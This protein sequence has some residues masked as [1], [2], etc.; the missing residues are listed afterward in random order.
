M[1]L[2]VAG[3]VIDIA[4]K[5]APYI[6]DGVKYAV[7]V[8]KNHVGRI[9]AL[10][11]ID[12]L[13]TEKE[14]QVAEL[15]GWFSANNIALPR[16]GSGILETIRDWVDNASQN[17]YKGKE[18]SK[19]EN[20]ARLEG[21]RLILEATKKKVMDAKKVGGMVG[22]HALKHRIVGG[23]VMVTTEA[24]IGGHS[25]TAAGIG[26]LTALRAG[27]TNALSRMKMRDGMDG[28]RSNPDYMSYAR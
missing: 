21:Y 27:P 22:P 25:R 6:I 26:G 9:D 1:A 8:G 23:E 2:A 12:A 20:L 10:R 13:V 11:K 5:A 17:W 16:E 14:K 4:I 18:K 15:K 7:A 3:K 24:K 19:L 28:V